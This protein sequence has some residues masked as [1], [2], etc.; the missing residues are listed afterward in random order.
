MLD[1]RLHG[2]RPRRGLGHHRLREDASP[3]NACLRALGQ[4]ARADGRGTVGPLHRRTRSMAATCAW[5]TPGRGRVPWSSIARLEMP[6][7]IDAADHAAGWLPGFAS[8]AAPGRAGPGEPDADRG[9][10]TAPASPPGRRA[11]G[12]ARSS[13]GGAR[14]QPRGRIGGPTGRRGNCT[15][16]R[17]PSS[18]G[19]RLRPRGSLAVWGG[20]AGRGRRLDRSGRWTEP[21]TAVEPLRRRPGNRSD[22][23]A[24]MRPEVDG[25]RVIR[26][27]GLI[28]SAARAAA[29]REPPWYASGP[30]GRLGL[31]CSHTSVGVLFRPPNTSPPAPRWNQEKPG[32]RTRPRRR[33]AVMPAKIVDSRTAPCRN[34]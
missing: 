15:F 7:G 14:T 18:T 17:R 5:A 32:R 1:G 21:R 13:R 2:I 28:R 3:P 23:P 34:P 19:P 29:A 24:D 33:P 12:V 20:A 11:P 6:S 9:C 25:S 4:G 30:F 16:R 27:N 8:A 26:P 31:R 10:R 22:R